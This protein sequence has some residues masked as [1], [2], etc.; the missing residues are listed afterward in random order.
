MSK[1]F[2]GKLADVCQSVDYGLTASAI[3]QPVGP[4]FLRITDIVGATLD[5]EQVPFVCA[6]SNDIR[7]FI[8]HDGDIV[9]ARTGATTGESRYI[10]D[11]PQAVFASYLIRLKVNRL[12]DPR[13]I[14]YWLKSPS[15]RGYIQGVLGDKSAQPNASAST[16]MRAPIRIPALVSEQNRISSILGML[17]DKI[18]LN[19]RM[20]K[21]LEAMARAI[22]KDWFIDFGPTRAKARGLP[23][24]LTPELWD[25]FP[26]VLDN[27]GKP[28]GW[29]VSCL[30]DRIEI[31]DS[32]RVPLSSRQRAYRQGS[33]PYH[34]AA[35]II[36]YVNDYLFDGIHVLVGEDGSVFKRDGKPFT[37][38]V[39][40][41]FWVN[42]H[43]HVLTG[44]DISN[45]MLLC[46]LQQINITPFVTGA[47]QPKLN[48]RNLS[49][50][51]FPPCEENVVKAFESIVGSVYGKVR[52]NSDESHTL[53]Q[54]RDMLLPRFMSGKI[55]LRD[56]E[57]AVEVA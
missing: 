1:L 5:W 9:I 33:Y 56:V 41:Q 46:F 11:P 3:N 4:K 44:K 2:V 12:N 28:A 20:N 42:N 49:R 35:G 15:F 45:E 57:K 29:A 25:L 51:P 27:E 26:D 55:C 48:Q 19:Q 18:E 14:S 7:K 54:T 16:M 17:D 21:T 39:W 10:I 13:F 22:F 37:Q 32:R 38:Y 31:H 40:G 34:G 47:V 8:L 43:A 24:Y 23:P 50:I 30:G 52:M 6:K 36:D 53:A